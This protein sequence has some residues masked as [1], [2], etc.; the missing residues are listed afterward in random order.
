MTEY[1]DYTSANNTV[2]QTYKLNHTNQTV[3]FVKS[4]MDLHCTKFDKCKMSINDII[5]LQNEIVDESD[6]DFD[7]AQIIHAYQTAERVRKMYPN[8]DY[9]HLVGLLHDCGKILLLD[10]F[11]GLNQWSVVGDTFPVGCQY[12]DKI[13][14]PEFF[15]DNPDYATNTLYGIYQPKCGIDNLLM[16][17]S[18]DIY[19]YSV[20]KHNGCLIP[21]DG[22]KVI[23]YHSF[24]SWHHHDA[25]EYFMNDSDHAIKYLCYNFSLCDLYSKN[26]DDID[27]DAVKPYYDELIKKYFPNP[28]LEW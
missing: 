23:R 3:E 7:N 9:L 4:M 6:P 19:A 20:F 24:Y 12:S 14:Y 18:H 2:S 21:E 11:D 22:L 8:E 25:Y 10:E 15:V 13:V 17:F 16:C 26:D 5:L 27:I 1:R 28:I